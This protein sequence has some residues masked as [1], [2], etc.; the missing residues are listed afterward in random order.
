MFCFSHLGRLPPPFL[1]LFTHDAFRRKWVEVGLTRPVS[2][3]TSQER[4]QKDQI[5]FPAAPKA[6]WETATPDPNPPPPH[7]LLPLHRSLIRIQRCERMLRVCSGAVAGAVVVVN[8]WFSR[9]KKSEI[10][11]LFSFSFIF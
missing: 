5:C 4:S 3:T 9:K 11:K 10:I 1:P 8:A 6:S 7:T 2:M